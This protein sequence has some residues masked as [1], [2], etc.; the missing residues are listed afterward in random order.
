MV[1]FSCISVVFVDTNSRC[2]FSAALSFVGNTEIIIKNELSRRYLVA[3]I[4]KISGCLESKAM[5][6]DSFSHTKLYSQQL[7]PII[8]AVSAVFFTL[9]FPRALSC[10]LSPNIVSVTSVIEPANQCN[11]TF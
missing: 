5:F 4:V 7:P 1:R 10:T 6:L 11:R 2:I 3:S 8:V 9:P